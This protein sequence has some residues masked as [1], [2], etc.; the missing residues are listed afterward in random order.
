[1][2]HDLDLIRSVC[3]TGMWLDSGESG[4]VAEMDEVADAYAPAMQDA[5]KADGR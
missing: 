2:S 1:M 4:C 3:S 5:A